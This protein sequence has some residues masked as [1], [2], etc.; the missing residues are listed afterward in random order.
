MLK[1]FRDNLKYLSW[2]LWLV[3]FVFVLFV[4]VDFGGTVQRG[5]GVPADAAA[6]VGDE[7]ISYREFERAYRNV[8]ATYREAYGPEFTSEMATQMGLPMQVLNQLINERLLLAEAGRMGLRVTDDELRKSIV[9]MPELQ[10]D[11]KFIG[12]E[13]YEQLL[14]ANRLS[15]DQFHAVRREAL[16][17]EKVRR[18]LA[19]SVFVPPADVEQAYRDRAETASIRYAAVPGSRFAAEVSVDA[20]AVAAY[21]EAHAEDFRLPER[22]VVRYVLA[23][24]DELAATQAVDEAEVRRAYDENPEQYER[25]EQ[26]RARHILIRT[27][28]E[29]D[30]AAARALAEDLLRRL[31]SGEDFAALAQEFSD[32]PGSKER[33]GDVGFFGRGEMTPPFEEA[34]FGGEPG[35][36]VGPVESDFGVHVIR[37]EEKRAGGKQPFEEVAPEIR[38]RLRREGAEAAA[39]A[40]AREVAGELEGRNPSS[41]EFAQAAGGSSVAT[42]EPFGREDAVPD[43]GRGTPFSTAAFELAQG[44]V[45]QA[46]RTPRGWAVLQLVEVQAPRAPQLDEVRPAVEG[47]VAEAQRLERARA[48]ATQLAAAVRGGR[49]LEEAAGEHGLT[50]EEAGPFGR[51]DSIPGLGRDEAVAE[52]AL[53]LEPG[54]VGGPVTAGEAAVVFVVTARQRFDPAAFEAAREQ[55]RERLTDERLG[56]L[57]ASLLTQRREELEVRIDPQ[58]LQN[59]G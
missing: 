30:Q 26:V 28:A 55:T 35:A 38:E 54:A 18:V 24:P 31:R 19:G 9:E 47:A 20:T 58:L 6:T 10:R 45:S 41:E 49:T 36:L 32:D 27:S 44:E 1:V 42:T 59:F 11:G 3:I 33:G 8:E 34:A 5:G 23:S 43:I 37:V 56:Q 14:A 29:R 57:M 7:E 2:I 4:F 50:V 17:A 40:R 16:L 39:E 48:V 52:A 51:R 12:R 15:I 21:F 46:V 13:A 53:A 22:R 25:P